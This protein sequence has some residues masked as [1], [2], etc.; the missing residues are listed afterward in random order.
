MLNTK[1][2]GP[3]G[4]CSFS[5]ETHSLMYS[6]FRE[7]FPNEDCLKKK[8]IS[9]ALL[10]FLLSHLAVVWKPHM[11]CKLSPVSDKLKRI[12]KVYP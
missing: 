1:D 7:A 8:K 4:T 3:N 9:L 5:K 2:T 12:C 6:K 11:Y 10:K